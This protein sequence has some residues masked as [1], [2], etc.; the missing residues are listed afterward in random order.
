MFKRF[1]LIMVV[2]MLL[3][4]FA[5]V[6]H[7]EPPTPFDP[8]IQYT[9]GGEP[10][11]CFAWDGQT[12]TETFGGVTYYIWFYDA[13]LPVCPMGVEMF[14]YSDSVQG[15]FVANT[16]LLGMPDASSGINVVMQIGK[17][18]WVHG[19]DATGSFFKISVGGAFAWVPVSSLQPNY[20]EVWNGAPL[21]VPVV[22]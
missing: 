4:T 2:V 12:Y 9:F 21:V 7:A 19:V 10:Y 8:V 6:A 16:Q 11:L 14:D 13:F 20:D 17:T 22:G 15:S 18:V 3:A 5:G 1:A